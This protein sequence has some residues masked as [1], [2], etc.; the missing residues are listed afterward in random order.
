[1]VSAPTSRNRPAIAQTSQS[2]TRTVQITADAA[3][4]VACGGGRVLRQQRNRLV[5]GLRLGRVAL[6]D[7]LVQA[8]GDRGEPVA[9]GLHHRD[10]LTQRRHG[11]RA[12]AAGVVEQHHRRVCRRPASRCGRSAPT[13]GR[14]QSSLSMSLTHDQV[15]LPPGVLDDLP[16]GVVDRLGLRRVREPD[17][18]GVHAGGPGDRRSGSGRA[19]AARR[20]GA[21]RCRLGWVKVC[22]PSSLPS[23]V[24]C[25]VELGVA[26]HLGADHEERAVRVVL[27]EHLQHLRRPAGSGPSSKV[28]A[29]VWV[30]IRLLLSWPPVVLMTGPPPR[31]DS[32]TPAWSPTSESRWSLVNSEL[33]YAWT[34]STPTKSTSSRPAEHDA[35]RGQAAFGGGVYPGRLAGMVASANGGFAGFGS[36]AGRSRRG[37]GSEGGRRRGGRRGVSLW[38]RDRARGALGGCRRFAAGAAARA[39]GVGAVPLAEALVAPSAVGVVPPAPARSVGASAARRAVP[40]WWCGAH[41]CGLVSVGGRVRL[42]AWPVGE[43]VAGWS[44]CLATPSAR[45]RRRR[46][47]LRRAGLRTR[48]GDSVPRPAAAVVAARARRDVA[49]DC[50]QDRRARGRRRSS[51]SRLQARQRQHGAGAAPGR[52]PG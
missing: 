22:R 48:I 11:L 6:L 19:P 44:G 25:L 49:P 10:V 23:S 29:M 14:C 1:M 46:R 27:L 42:A 50:G 32:G 38:T 36:P 8:L 15:A 21:M 20:Q 13:P 35:G 30:G 9:A 41:R 26:G 18:V 7:G 43:V 51:L 47:R 5:A 3:P 2:A 4:H 24:I 37:V 31:I 28:S 39:G 34:T 12:V 17:Q 40:P 33:M 52:R 45:C 16:V